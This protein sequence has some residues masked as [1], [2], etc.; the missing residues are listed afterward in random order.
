MDYKKEIGRRIRELR[1]ERGWTLQEMSRKTRDV[2]SFQRIGAYEKGDRMPG[3]SEAVVLAHA[4]SCRAAYILAVDDN[5]LPISK[6]EEV[7]IR[8]WRALPENRRMSHYRE[9][10]TESLQFRDPVSDQAVDKHIPRA[11]P[12]TRSTR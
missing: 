10:E 1:E 4:L 2:L 11:K 3:P 9:I 5:Q 7:L 8:N 6:Q 12:R